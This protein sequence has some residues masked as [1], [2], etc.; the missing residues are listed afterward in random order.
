MF[1]YAFDIHPPNDDA[2]TH[3]DEP[4]PAQRPGFVGAVALALFRRVARL[5]FREIEVVGEVP[6]PAIEGRIFA[7]N[8]FN[9]LVDPILVLTNAPCP[10]AP[11]AKATLWK[12][13]VLA[14]LLDSVGAV[15]VLRRK[16]D[17]N[18]PAEANDAVFARVAGHLR[19]G[20][21]VLIFPE[22]ISHDEPQVVRLKSGAGR[23]L[24]RAQSEGARDLTYQAVGLE[25]DARDVFR[26]RAL[27]VYGP[28]RR[29]D[30]HATTTDDLAR[31]I[32]DELA[33]DLAELVVEGSTW[34][35]RLLVARVAEMFANGAGER[36]MAGL[37]EIGR[38]VEAARKS[39]GA[40]DAIAKAVGDYYASL[41]E[42]GLADHDIETSGAPPRSRKTTR[43]K[44]ALTLPLAIPG[45]VLWWVPYQIPRLVSRLL[46]KGE[47]NVVSTYKLATGLV[48]FPLWG[49]GLTAASM[50]L[51]P[52]PFGICVAGAALASAPAALVW[53]DWLDRPRRRH[54]ADADGLRRQRA[55]VMTLLGDAR[56]RA[57]P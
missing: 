25:F 15:P 14:Q 36:T 3:H 37:N 49:A 51:V 48:V 50:A 10:I 4:V 5:Y 23:M 31:A 7:A 13:P 54:A 30:A 33:A 16:D 28:V 1:S 55:S 24:A 20:G 56:E 32:T 47:G 19:G 22:G 29:V 57:H 12:I 38:V 6:T 53:I 9:G 45:A 26:S 41:A 21:N 39:L 40:Y 44:L 35:E 17:P 8:H 27:V 43:L 46:A 18:K 2:T 42:A 52:W 34:D 11:V